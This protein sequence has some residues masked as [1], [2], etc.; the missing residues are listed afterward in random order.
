MTEELR[1]TPFEHAVMRRTPVG[2]WGNAS[3]LVGTCV[4]LASGASD[5]VTGAVI[6]V[7]GGYTA[8]DGLDRD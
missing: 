4:Y 2:R 8:N 1:G 7:D 3:D 6:P 5:Y